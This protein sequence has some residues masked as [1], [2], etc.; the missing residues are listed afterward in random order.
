MLK[1]NPK[2]SKTFREL[3]YPKATLTIAYTPLR[4]LLSFFLHWVYDPNGEKA[5]R[6]SK[7]VQEKHFSEE[8]LNSIQIKSPPIAIK[9]KLPWNSPKQFYFC[10]CFF[11]FSG[12]F[13]T[14]HT[15]G[16]VL[17]TIFTF[18]IAS[19]LPK[20]KIT[21]AYMPVEPPF[22]LSTLNPPMSP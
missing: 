4:N 5:V 9:Q 17:G 10:Y 3:T 22:S 14:A 18:I 16:A 20:R 21:M 12:S 8:I 11:S 6:D 1:Q 19:G 7:R 15:E 13:T 2:G